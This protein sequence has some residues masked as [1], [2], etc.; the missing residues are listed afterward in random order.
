[1]ERLLAVLVVGVSLV[2]ILAPLRDSAAR[3][4]GAFSR[5]VG[6]LRPKGGALGRSR[7]AAA[8]A[9][10][11]LRAAGQRVASGRWLLAEVPRAEQAL[12]R[13]LSPAGAGAG[14]VVAAPSGNPE[15]Q[16]HWVRDAAIAMD[17]VLAGLIDSRPGRRRDE[18]LGIYRDYVGFSRRLLDTATQ[19]GLGEPKYALDGGPFDLV[20]GRPQND[21]PAR[22]ALG[23]IAFARWLAREGRRDAQAGPDGAAQVPADPHGLIR[24]DLDYLVDH[25]REPSFD[26]WEEEKGDHF[27]TRLVQE[28]ALARGA[29]LARSWGDCQASD[30]YAAAARDIGAELDRHWDPERGILV[31]TLPGSH[32]G[33]IDYKHSGLD[34]SVVLGVLHAGGGG[35]FTASDERVLATAHRLVEVFRQLFPINHGRDRAAAVAIGRYPEDRYTGQPGQDREGGG[36]AWVITTHALAELD[37]LVAGEIRRAGT[38]TIGALN[39]PFYLAALGHDPASDALPAGTVLASGTGALRSLVASLV[40][41]GDATLRLTRDATRAGGCQREQIDREA[42]HMVGADELTWNYASFLSATRARTRALRARQ[43]PGRSAHAARVPRA[44]PGALPAPVAIH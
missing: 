39:R 21:G 5:I 35:S 22:R 36:N 37:Y 30:R 8:D 33:G 9:G 10:R 13:N 12:R 3:V 40:A 15:Y 4:V 41:R 19:T 23:N 26:I 42:G 1:M 38:V 32:Q 44:R 34:V 28:R 43:V 25:W 11:G 17:E 14:A 31:A 18:L 6:L 27:Y 2:V 16:F 7:Q 29:A 24:A 20:W